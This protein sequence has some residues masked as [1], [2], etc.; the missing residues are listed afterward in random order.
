MLQC[1]VVCCSALPCVV[2]IVGNTTGNLYGVAGVLQCT[3]VCCIV[4][5]CAVVCCGVLQCVAVC[6]SVLPCVV[7]IVGNTTGNLYGVAGVLH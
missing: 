6:Y 7:K 4:L 3:V 5:Y 2:K 1:S